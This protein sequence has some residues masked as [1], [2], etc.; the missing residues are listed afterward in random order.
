MLTAD[1]VGAVATAAV[2]IAQG[3]PRVDDGHAAWSPE[4]RYVAF[5][6]VRQLD[7][8]Y[9][10]TSIYVVRADG[11]L[12]HGIT[13]RSEPADAVEPV[14]SPDGRWIAFVIATKYFPPHVWWTRR[15]GRTARTPVGGGD[16]SNREVSPSW[17]PDGRRLAFAGRLAGRSGLYV[18]DRDSGRTR[19]VVAGDVNAAAWSPDGGRIAFSDATSIAV[20]RAAGGPATRLAA[21]PGVVAWSPDGSRLAYASVCSVAVVAADATGPPPQPPP[22]PPETETSVPSWSPTGRRFAYSNCRHLVCS[23]LVLSPGTAAPH[24]VYVARGRDPAWSPTGGEIAYTRVTRGF[25]PA[26]I[27]VVH[28]DGTHDH[29]LVVGRRR[30]GR[31][32]LA[33]RRVLRNRRSRV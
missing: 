21:P 13:Q 32:A 18:A 17:S 6:R 26:R 19:L 33:P 1:V 23:V 12:L 8:G 2:A 11:R 30:A 29:P 7:A 28:P 5:D 3:A 10:N 20:V 16:T 25:K 24:P 27:H 4:G 22:C 15:N 9:T 14:W 31:S